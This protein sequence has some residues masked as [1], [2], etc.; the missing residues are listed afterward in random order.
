M[1]IILLGPIFFY[2]CSIFSG[3]AQSL[4]YVFE[5]SSRYKDNEIYIGLVGQYPGMGNVWM[6]MSKSQLKYMEY[7]NNTMPG[8][9]WANTPDGKNK[10]ANMFYKLSDI[11]NKTI[12]IPHGLFGCRILISFKSPMYIYFHKN[13]G[14]AGANLQNSNDPNDGIRWELVELTWGNAGLWT[15]TSRVDA[16]QYPMGLEV[17]GYTGGINASYQASYN[18]RVNSGASPDVNK[19]IGELISHQTILNAWPQKVD[20]PFF[21]CKLV[22]RHSLDNEPIIEQPSKIDDFKSNGPHKDYF[23]TYIN[24]IWNTYRSKDLLLNIGDRGT[25]RGRVTGDRFDFYDPADNSQATIY[26]KPTTQDAIEGAGA[27]ATTYAAA[28]SAKY[29]EDLMIQAQVCAAI[30]RHAI[31]T[32]APTGEVQYNHDSNRFF[33]Y[34]PHNQ[35]VKFFH[36]TDISYLS[37]TYAFAYDDVGDQSSTIQCTFPSKVKVVVGGYGEKIASPLIVPGIIQAE[38]YSNMN[39]VQLEPTSDVGGSDNVGYI[40][41]ADWLEYNVTVTNTGNYDFDFRSASLGNGG[42]L[43]LE[44]DGIKATEITLPITGGWQN[45]YTTLQR[46]I[47]LTK[48]NHNLKVI[49]TKGG[50]NLNYFTVSESIKSTTGLGFIRAEGKNIVNDNG[51]YQIRAINIGNYMVQEGYMLNLGG[52]YQYVIKQKLTEVVGAANTEKFYKDYKTNF[53]V[54]ADIDSLAKWGFNSIRLPMHYNL[55]TELG[56]P[57]LFIE[58]GFALVDQIISWCK[59]NKM[60]VI[61]DLHAAPGGQNSGD[62]SDYI[63]GQSSLWEDAPGSTFTSAQNRT[64]TIALW[65]EFARRYAEEETVA[66]Y[67]LI[68]ETNWT[69]PGNVL[70][71][72]LMKDIT[73]AIRSIDKKHHIFIEGN[74]YANDYTG[75]T[76][77]WDNNMS[78]SFHKYWNDVNDGSLNFIFKMRD[79]QNVPIWLGEFGENSNHW[80]QETIELMNK[81]NIGWAVWPYKKMG[82]VSSAMAFKEPENWSL[83]AQFIKGEG[84]KPSATTGQEILNE[85]V[86]NVKLNNCSLNKGYLNALFPDQNNEV[87]PFQLVTLPASILA[88]H[89]DEGKNGL[90]YNDVIYR[91]TQFG[92]AGGDYTAWNSGWY[93]RNDGVDIQYSTSEKQPI[94]A[95][96]EASEW[97]SYTVQAAR[98][99]NFLVKARVAGYGGELSVLVDGIKVIDKAK[100]SATGDWDGWK[101]IDLGNI[102]LTSGKQQIKILVEKSGFNLG[103][104][105][106]LEPLPTTVENLDIE[107]KILITATAFQD[108]THLM[109][110]ETTNVP[111][112]IQVMNIQGKLVCT[113]TGLTGESIIVGTELST[114]LYILKVSYLNKTE[115]IKVIKQ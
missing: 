50:F 79:E 51:N 90:A 111:V 2:I 31:H 110:L 42:T 77:K 28:P 87:K 73:M 98:T 74:S 25:W 114:G 71:F 76:P 66:G 60:Y 44:I 54:K 35:Y 8:P 15:N 38:D 19:K 53:L 23:A 82:S 64:Q 39:G 113:T 14:Y 12:Q 59:A 45:W 84:T 30:N 27:L 83:L 4:P 104:I 47:S 91:T 34:F 89:Y 96:L 101:T 17:T 9:A 6:D 75:M 61:L 58:N 32:N 36:D 112:I 99:G 46:K 20:A 63:A 108:Q 48:G 81:H 49:A 94:V 37:Q 115:I 29:D 3:K 10:Y 18:A 100:V 72:N 13:G 86:N 106:F 11:P 43:V 102:N 24:N 70:L 56:K 97:M 92:A 109:V 62:I 1:K 95:W 55:F 26:R 21:G 52:G 105:E 78:Y 40:D 80:I 7:A 85:L 65:K 88:A 16:Y 69:I 107:N 5:N 67:D 57:D 93:Y 103:N 41:N 33:N 22:K 68:N